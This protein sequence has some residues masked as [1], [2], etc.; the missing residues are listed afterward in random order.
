[1]YTKLVIGSNSPSISPRVRKKRR[2]IVLSESEILERNREKLQRLEAH[3]N[4]IYDQ[5]LYKSCSKS[6]CN[7][8]PIERKIDTVQLFLKEMMD[9]NDLETETCVVCYMKKALNKLTSVS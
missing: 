1:M 4:N 8:I 6:W 7:P 9:E 2:R 5:K 3:V